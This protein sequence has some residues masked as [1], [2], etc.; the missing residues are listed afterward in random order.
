M[1]AVQPNSATDV[2]V[3]ND[4]VTQ[5]TARSALA[6]LRIAFGVT[7]LWAFFDKLLALGYATGKNPET[8]AVDRFGPDAWI[9]DGNPTLGF[10]KFGVSEDNWFHGFFTSIAGDAWTNWLFMAGLAGI[11]FALLFGVGM[12]IAGAAGAVLYLLMWAASFP[13]ENNPV[14]DD[15]LLGAISV[16]VLAVTLSGDTW[17]FGKAWAKTSIVRRFPV[18]R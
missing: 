5:S 11:G 13:L 14:V 6:A 4:I 1:T 17:G 7:F 18:L 8:G 2:L 3:E 16:I 9:N 15:H 12:R 10:L